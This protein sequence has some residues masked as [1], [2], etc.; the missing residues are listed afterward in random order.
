MPIY[1]QI[2]ELRRDHNLLL[3]HLGELTILLKKKIDL[4]KFET[5]VLDEADRMLD[6]GFINDM[7]FLMRSMPK[8]HQTLFFSAT[9]SADIKKLLT[10]S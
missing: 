10:I 2:N 5:I 6:M 7:R 9:L 4:G 3:V 1:R 8:D